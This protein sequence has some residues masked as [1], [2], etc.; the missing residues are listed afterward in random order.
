[1]KMQI[2]ESCTMV[3]DAALLKLMGGRSAQKPMPFSEIISKTGATTDILNQRLDY[4]YK[5]RAINQANVF[6]NGVWETNCWPT[7]VVPKAAPQNFVINS[8]KNVRIQQERAT[9]MNQTTKLTTKVTVKQIVEY[10]LNNEPIC[11]YDLGTK[12]AEITDGDPI[13]IRDLAQYLRKMNVLQFTK[14]VP[15]IIGSNEKWFAQNGLVP[16]LRTLTAS[17]SVE[18]QEIVRTV[19][20][21]EEMSIKVTAVQIVK[22]IF[23]HGSMRRDDLISQI[24]AETGGIPTKILD[25]IY[26]CKRTNTLNLIDGMVSLGNNTTWLHKNGFV[27]PN[28]QPINAEKIKIPNFLRKEKNPEILTDADAIAH[29]PETKSE[30][31]TTPTTTLLKVVPLTRKIEVPI[32]DHL[33]AIATVLPQGV[34][35]NI[36]THPDTGITTYSLQ[37][38]AGANYVVESDVHAITRCID[39]LVVL[40]QFTGGSLQKIMHAL[41]PS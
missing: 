9:Q 4:L 12:L 39:A 19:E 1:M 20:V 31:L 29:I 35:L 5:N 8:D 41:N 40:H 3:T 34:C 38:G 21:A 15:I 6:R 2:S 32:T 33:A 24:T 16:V 14:S 18:K 23:E 25:M 17:L 36:F 10:V 28:I 37:T 11:V 7:G 27:M 30:P 26:Y 13:K 22:H